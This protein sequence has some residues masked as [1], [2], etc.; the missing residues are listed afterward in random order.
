MDVRDDQHV[1]PNPFVDI[2][3]GHWARM[4]VDWLSHHEIT[5]GYADKTLRPA[6]WLAE[7]DRTWLGRIGWAVMDLSGPY[8]ATF[9]TVL[10]DA[11]Q[12]ADAFQLVKLANERLD[13]RGDTKLTGLLRAGDPR[14]EVAYTWHANHLALGGVGQ[15]ARCG[16]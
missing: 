9:D 1:R 13:A 16:C 8:R 2:P 5:T 12:V 10:P 6:G 14:G 11:T 4:A 7:Q 15:P 3:Q